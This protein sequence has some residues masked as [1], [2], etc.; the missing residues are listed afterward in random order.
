[1]KKVLIELPEDVIKAAKKSAV[2]R[3]VSL[4]LL[5]AEALRHYLGLSERKDGR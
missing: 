3:D 5:V 1:M 2:D 4:K